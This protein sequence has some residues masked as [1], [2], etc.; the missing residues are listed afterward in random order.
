[1]DQTERIE[2]APYRSKGAPA[3][4]SKAPRQRWSHLPRKHLTLGQVKNNWAALGHA[5]RL[6]LR[7]N[8]HLDISFRV[9]GLDDPDR[10]A[11]ASLRAFLKL[12]RQWIERRGGQTAYIYTLEN[13]YSGIAETGIHAHVL[14]HVPDALRED[15]HRQK[16]I[17]ASNP[18]VGM[19]WKPGLFGPKGEKR[20]PIPT[21]EG[22]KG[23]LRYMSKDL[24][25][26]HWPIFKAC[27]R[28]HIPGHP[29]SLDNRGKPS[30]APVYGLKTGVSR[31]INAKARSANGRHL[32]ESA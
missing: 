3:L 18:L 10:T 16:R 9:G 20:P 22:V 26:R 21:L 13:R 25:P 31:N 19:S 4:P 7:P 12:A 8:V 23:K 27:P 14:I 32:V 28:F 15:F 2:A 29:P 5:E 1:M 6:G 30:N 17:W 24:E 11:S